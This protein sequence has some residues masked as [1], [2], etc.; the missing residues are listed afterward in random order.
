M[1]SKKTQDASTATY[2]MRYSDDF[3]KL[4]RRR[5]AQTS[6]A[7]LLPHLEPGM[8]VLDFGCGPG[9]IRDRTGRCGGQRTPKR[10]IQDR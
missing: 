1:N 9:T 2:A 3:Q 8:R 6:A 4:L 10:G 7:H 5:N